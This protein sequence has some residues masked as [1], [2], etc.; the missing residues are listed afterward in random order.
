MFFK[1][2]QK[3]NKKTNKF[4]LLK[5]QFSIFTHIVPGVAVNAPGIVG[6]QSVPALHSV[7]SGPVNSSNSADLE[8]AYVSSSNESG[9]MSPEH[10][11]SQQPP[12]SLFQTIPP[13]DPTS[14]TRAKVI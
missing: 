5:C 10:C 3:Q 6:L 4:D 9:T 14:A 7:P 2:K 11:H 8:S 13:S 1:Q 12:Q